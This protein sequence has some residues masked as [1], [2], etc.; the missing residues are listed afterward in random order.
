MIR[1]KPLDDQVV[2][3]TGASSGIG[4]AT[5]QLAA[6]RGA[7]VVLV[8]RSR[9]A[10]ALAVDG[11]NQA[12]PGRASFVEADVSLAESHE[13]TIAH[14]IE[15]HGRID[16][17]INGAGVLTFGMLAET[18]EADMRR[19]FDVNFWGL[20]HG[21][22]AAARYFRSAGGGAIINVGSLESDLGVPLQG[23]Y[24]ASKHAVKGF[25]DVLRAELHADGVPVA[26]TLVKP[27]A[28]GT[29]LPQ[30]ARTY[31]ASEPRFPPPVYSPEEAAR[32]I[33]SAAEKPMRTVYV[34]GAARMLSALSGAAPGLMSLVQKTIMEPMQLSGRPATPG[35]NLQSGGGEAKVRSDDPSVTM[36]PSLYSLAS[37]HRLAAT[38][39]VGGLAAAFV[40]LA[41]SVG[42]AKGKGRDDAAPAPLE[43]V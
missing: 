32:S 30:H 15:R 22:L 17:W 11:I 18:P 36:R 19:L 8:A 31:G 39:L 40:L 29:P 5:A 23:I 42:G 21:S 35:D 26:V 34:G 9:P 4:L 41:R 28:I 1:L 3:I 37:R 43:A 16:T 24:G 12:A 33:L 20:V 25:T 38:A 2:V 27:G 7:H 10:L 13:R 14:A 6:A